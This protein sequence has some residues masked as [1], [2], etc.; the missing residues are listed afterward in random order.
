MPALH[1]MHMGIIAMQH[2][3]GS[4]LSGL[5]G[6]ASVTGAGRVGCVGLVATPVALPSS[7]AAV[8]TGQVGVS[9][10]PALAQ[11][12]VSGMGAVP[13]SDTGRHDDW[14]DAFSLKSGSS[15]AHDVAA[16]VNGVLKFSTHVPSAMPIL[17]LVCAWRNTATW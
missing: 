3:G 10:A 4:V 15:R 13:H 17:P 14:S 12:F 6:M 9:T 16:S 11:A 1:A 8:S 7:G 2:I 5:V